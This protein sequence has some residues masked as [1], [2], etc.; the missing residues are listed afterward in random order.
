MLSHGGWGPETPI[1]AREYFYSLVRKLRREGGAQEILSSTDPRAGEFVEI[2]G[3]PDKLEF[4]AG[5]RIILSTCDRLEVYQGT[6]GVA[7]DTVRHLFELASGLRS[8]LVGENAVLG[9]IR[10]AY[11]DAVARQNDANRA[12]AVA[13][14]GA[15]ECSD[16]RV[17]VG[18]SAQP[19]PAPSRP[20][21][22]NSWRLSPELHAL[23]QSALACG[24]EVR[25]RTSISQGAVGHAAAVLQ[26]LKTR[27]SLAGKRVLLVGANK[28]I[29]SV[30]AWLADEGCADICVINRD[31]EK[32]RQLAALA[33]CRSAGFEDLAAETGS[34]DVLVSATSAPHFMIRGENHSAKPGALWFDLAMPRDVDPAF[35]AQV[36]LFDVAGIEAAVAD[37]LLGRRAEIPRAQKIVDEAVARF[38]EREQRRQTVRARD[39][40]VAVGPL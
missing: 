22:D 8:P 24:K 39:L 1:E 30:L 40:Q 4:P 35:A 2:L 12:P 13:G 25:T 19:E 29:E 36:E 26:I 33:N 6:G 18:W 21:A 11:E 10:R 15:A 32:A 23:F 7:K 17:R 3:G 38:F 34:A 5:G 16:C 31:T 37:A 14:L 9:Q 27:G 28:I 20:L